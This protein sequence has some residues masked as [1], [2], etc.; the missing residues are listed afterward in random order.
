MNKIR[1][2]LLTG[3]IILA[4]YLGFRHQVI[5]GGPTG[6]PPID[7]YCPFGGLETLPHYLTTGSFLQK[8]A[9]SNFWLLVAVIVTTLLAG[10][11]FC[12]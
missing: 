10:A 3:F 2:A 1:L 11:L 12:G 5:G 4:T 7:A 9:P 8:T 6:V